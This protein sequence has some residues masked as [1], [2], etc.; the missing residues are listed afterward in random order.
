MKSKNIFGLAALLFGTGCAQMNYMEKPKDFPVYSSEVLGSEHGFKEIGCENSNLIDE[1]N[2]PKIEGD[3]AFVVGYSLAHS[4]ESA[5]RDDAEFNGRLKIKEL[6]GKDGKTRIMGSY[7]S[8][9]EIHKIMSK[10]GDIG[11]TAHCL[12]EAPLSGIKR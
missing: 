5:A 9:T 8:K 11:Y 1:C 7:T 10:N 12:M 4:T 3:T 2:Y 6:Y